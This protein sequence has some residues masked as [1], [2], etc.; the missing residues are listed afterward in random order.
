M[1]ANHNLP[2]LNLPTKQETIAWLRLI[3][4]EGIGPIT[5]YSLLDKFGSASEALYGLPDFAKKSGRKK[6]LA[7]YSE[8]QALKECADLKSYGARLILANDPNYPDALKTLS[9]A[10]PVLSVKGP[11]LLN[12]PVLA[13][14]GARNASLNA[15]NFTTKI[16]R[17]LGQLGWP[18]A[19]GLARGIDTA[20]HKGALATGTIAILAGGIDYIYPPENASLYQQIAEQGSIVSEVPFGTVPQASFFPRRNRIISGISRG[21]VIIE[22]A[23]KSGSLITARTAL[24][25]GREIFAVPGSPFDP[26]SQGCNHLIQ[27]GAL[28]VQSAEDIVATVS[29]DFSPQSRANPDQ[30]LNS[31][32]I[33]SDADLKSAHKIILKNLNYNPIGLDE[34]AQQCQMCPKMIQFVL[35]ELE[36]AGALHRYPG[37]RVALVFNG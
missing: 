14:V 8:T 33:L 1:G 36:L 13:I 25:Q 17:E 6:P 5:F 21:V 4:T 24:D 16:A 9:D 20:A 22:A 11:A 19:S 2:S 28:L 15:Q 18:I 30:S 26:R 3:R 35:L 31:P 27:Q 10:P 7:I 12:Q 37:N 34:L 32:N 29:G 23:L